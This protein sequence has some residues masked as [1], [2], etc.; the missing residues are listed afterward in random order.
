RT[1]SPDKADPGDAGTDRGRGDLRRPGKRSD[2]LSGNRLIIQPRSDQRI[3]HGGCTMNRRRLLQAVAA[4]P[5]LSGS[6]R[7]WPRPAPAA[8]A[9]PSSS[10][11]VRPGD[12]EWPSATSWERLNRDVGGRLI[13]VESPLA[14]CLDAPESATCA[15]VFDSLKNPYYLGDE[16]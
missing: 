12:P 16:V 4:I 10:S 7:R 2:E 6:C 8:A 15:H 9:G 11:R 13:E 1:G 5:L 3:S 14:A